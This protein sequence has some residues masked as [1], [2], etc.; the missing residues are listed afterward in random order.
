M[1]TTAELATALEEWAIAELPD[2][3]GSYDFPTAEKTQPLP[4]VAIE[5]DGVNT[6][7]N[8]PDA[9]LE[10]M[11][12]IQQTAMRTWVVRLL[13]MVKPEPGDVASQQL[14][15]FVDKLQASLMSDGTLGGRV[16]W[17]SKE[18]RGSFT[19]PFVQFDDGTRGRAATLEITV[20]EPIPYEE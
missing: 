6:S 18:T 5:V 11:F 8:P 17:T 16:S 13:L 4:D 10:A 2:I 15:G 20:G 1:M 7:L 3:K 12:A 14:A 19:P 9:S